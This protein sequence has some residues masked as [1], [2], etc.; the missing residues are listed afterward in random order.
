MASNVED[1]QPLTPL[2]QGMVFH[3]L[4]GEGVDV[5]TMQTVL[6]LSG[7]VAVDRLRTAADQLMRRHTTL[8]ASFRTQSSGQFVQVVYRSVDLPWREVDCADP[9]ALQRL[10]ES[11]RTASFDLGRPPLV[12]FTLARTATGPVLIISA[13]HLLWDGWSAPVLVREL[14]TLYSGDA[15]PPVRPFRDYLSWLSKQ[16]TEAASRAWA[17]ALSGLD[18]PTLVA[19]EGAPSGLPSFVDTTLP[20]STTAA[21]T[22]TA[23]D[24]GLT[25]NSV[26]QAAWALVL[27]EQ[28]GREDVVFGAT[29]SGRHPD[30]AGVES[31][32]GMLINTVPARIRLSPTETLAELATR[33]QAEQAAL[34]DHQHLGLA[35]VQQAAGRPTLFDTLLAFESYPG[36]DFEDSLVTAIESRDATHYPLAL[37]VVP[38]ESLSLRFAHD[39]ARF[40]AVDRVAARLLDVLERFAA[41]PDLPVARLEPLS[42]AE[43]H[44][45]V[46]VPNA[47][48]HPVPDT[49]LV[50][51]FSAQA[52]RTPDATAV[53]YEDSSLT[54]REFDARVDELA[55]QLAARG[56]R[57]GS[58]VG[59]HL[60]RSLELIIAL[61]AVQ[62]AG[63]AYLPLDPSYPADRLAMMIEDAQPV[64]V[65]EPG[66]LD[67]PT[68]P[69]RRPTPGDAAY[70]IFTSG[71]TGR[72]KGV[73]VSQRAIVNH[74]LWMQDE[75]RL[76]ADDR[77][78]QKTPSSFDISVW[79]FFW[80]LITGATLVVAKPE[81]HKDPAYLADLIDRSGITTIHFVPSMFRAFVESGARPSSL[82]RIILVGEALPSDL[83]AALPHV[84]N[85]YGPTEATLQITYWP[86]SAGVGNGTVPIGVPCWNSQV[87]VLDG[88]LRPVPEGVAGELYL[89]GIQLADGYLNRPGLTASRFVANP[90]TA[91][92]RLYRTGD[93]VRWNGVALEYLGR[94]DDQVKIRGIRVELGEIEAALMALP[95]VRAA[96]A[97]VFTERQQ[98]IGYVVGDGLDL[99]AARRALRDQLPEQLVPSTIIVLAEMPLTPNGKLNRKAL[100]LPEVT[101]AAGEAAR[102]PREQVLAGLFAD[103]LGVERVGRDDD[104][105]AL[106]GHSLLATKLVSRIRRTLN[107]DLR[108]RAVFDAPTVA[109]LARSLDG[110]AR[111]PELVARERPAV[112]PMSAAQRSLWFLYRLEGPDATYNVP[113]AARLTGR[114]DV[115][116]LDAA[117]ADV[118][119]RH[120]SL[121]TLLSDEGQHV[122]DAPLV[123]MVRRSGLDEGLDD[124]EFVAAATNRPFRLDQEIP[125]RA[126]LLAVGPAE[127]VLTLVVHHSAADEW[128]A[129]PLFRDLATAY[130]ARRQGEAP[131]WTPLPVQYA[132]FAL[133]QQE[134]PTDDERA[135]WTSKLAGLPEVIALPAD[136]ARPREATRDAGS[137]TIEFPDGLAGQ[138]RALGRK[139]GVTELMIGQA[140]TAVLLAAMGAGEDVPLG[141]P[142]AGRTDAAVDDVVGYFVN[143]L[144]LRTDVSGNPTFR[145]L[146]AQ[147]RDADL[148][149]FSHQDLPFE[150]VVDALNP[151][152]SPG[153][154][155]LFQVMVSRRDDGATDLAL[156]DLA[157]EQIVT[158]VTGAK[159]DLAFHFGD[160]D[161]LITYSA[162]RF[163]KSTVDS[164]ARRLVQVLTTLVT[165]P[166]Q[167]INTVDLLDD[168]ERAVLDGFNDT[169][170]ERLATTLTAMVEEQVARTPQAVAVEF[171]ERSLTYAELN[172]KANHLARRLQ[173]AGVGPERTVGMHWERSL[174]LVVGLLAVEKA[175]G[176]F[177]PLEPSWPRQRIAEV[178]DSARFTAVLSGPEHDEPVRDLNIPVLHV[179]LASENAENLGVHI[180]PESLAYVIYTSGSTGR[181]KGAMIRHR[182]ITHR[183]LWQRELLG[184]GPGDGG[185]FKAPLGF[186]ISIN[187]VFLPLTTGAKLVIA[188]PGGERDIDYLA[189]IIERHGVTYTYLP[190]SIL[191]LLVSLPDFERRGRSLKHVWCGGEVLTP[192]LFARFRALSDAVMY[193]GYGPAEATIGVSHIVYREPSAMRGAVSIGHPNGNTQLHVLDTN[194]RRVPVGVP[195]ELYA[196]GVYL[197]R[198]YINDPGRTAAAFVADPFGPPGSRLYRTGDLARWCPDGTLEFL[199]RADNQIKIRGM[200]VELEE[201]EAVLEQH[202]DVR[203]AVV[204]LRDKRLVGYHIGS[205]V[206][207]LGDWL[208]TRLPD[209]M[210]PQR[211]VFL[212]EFPLLPSGKVNRKAL[213]EPPAE[214][215]GGRDAET[216]AE[217]LLCGLMAEVLKLDRVSPDDNFF[218]LGGDSILSIQF[219]TR[220]R[221]AGLRI[222]PRQVFEF[223][224]AAALARVVG[225]PPAAYDEE[226]ARGVGDVPLTPIIRWWTTSG[227]EK[228][229]QSALLRVPPADGPEPFA[230]AVSALLEHH[231]MLRARFADGVLTVPAATPDG[232]FTHVQ[233]DGELEPLVRREFERVSAELD[234]AAGTLVRAVWFDLGPSTPGRLLLAV[235]HLAVDSVSWRVLAGDLEQA[236]TAR[237]AGNA[238]KLDPVPTSF[239]WWARNLP[240]PP[241]SEAQWW[242]QQ[243]FTVTEPVRPGPTAGW[244]TV[245]IGGDLAGAL[246]REVPGAFRAG[247]QDVLL[248]ALAT[249][250]GKAET[251]ALEGHGREEHLVPGADL[252]HTVG[253]FTTVYPVTLAPAGTP[254]ETLKQVKEKLRAVPNNGIGYGLLNGAADPA[255]GF[256]YLGRF[257]I[258]DGYWVPAAERLPRSR[259]QHR[260]LEI[261]IVTE[262]RAEGPVLKATWS[263]TGAHTQSEVDSIAQAWLAALETLVE[264]ARGGQVSALTP[265]DVPL[266]SL[267]Q[268]QLDKIAAKWRK[269]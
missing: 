29:V 215:T 132:D 228:M 171:H 114:L 104:F 142:V 157:V 113:F 92:R 164:L 44:A 81:G 190:S 4:L 38:G 177:V 96:A 195:G 49:T 265:S 137:V 35:D 50:E 108:I 205:E 260:P 62:R 256:N 169:A 209:H 238:V 134:L 111:R 105:F 230:E 58:I 69:V 91:G 150:Q 121:R 127:H 53:V 21:L 204:L 174:E 226:R 148:D 206:D 52:G 43:F 30:V 19:A 240:T 79:E 201:I 123:K 83:G 40:T 245:E 116:A 63:A 106:G 118:V 223:Q 184:F 103:V 8:R 74:L 179:D 37:L 18:G 237:V 32:V 138:I 55:G 227:D 68:A 182:A 122:Q 199:G 258:P 76:T 239:R 120:E 9:E 64:V 87:Y 187:E 154:H 125:F 146:L 186:D 10:L 70:V 153:L 90:F 212:D 131:Q 211:F 72:P 80:P 162:D 249:A 259:I 242:R 261:D 221:S 36:T 173:E 27:G 48:A 232:V 3:A 143:T 84:H 130:A 126:E 117:I 16:D 28:T 216:A 194:L 56:V 57:P 248:A 100:P 250:L 247:V 269:K 257:D 233:V 102:D 161:C 196:G 129:R 191:D 31:I 144:V 224:N 244:R 46:E 175:G 73:V 152:R 158:E 207:D 176:A 255:I 11:D 188:E 14:L 17:D 47:T 167:R 200:R 42:P 88:Y 82:K 236:F 12:R 183:L 107:V 180:E 2:Q 139:L 128:S 26:V 219:V 109:R 166:E 7:D 253:W 34:L 22:R 229:A 39:P 99:T 89:G 185:L 251:V 243:A 112:V 66:L 235:H 136:R 23:R 78:L 86:A 77:V 97:H 93:V 119:A 133:W 254:G 264:Q 170:E 234:P 51:L 210:V 24:R 214:Q 222:S 1:V 193:H 163:D 198:G 203:R 15:L 218:T 115:D 6:H 262:D 67:G 94:S 149:A 197:G 181:P 151:P 101:Q 33:V 225:E 147:V 45:V 172:A 135:Y 5:Y 268:N 192:E 41:T 13:H 54:Y 25:V 241:D 60:D 110:G 208:R 202:E 59:V 61:H 159:F 155:P 165:E 140:A 145:E 217:K 263:W 95:G 20:A 71:S 141:T 156:A 75:Y 178:A 160:D 246:L 85:L 189:E 98:L 65:L 124:A 267:P 213:P 168:A 252:S 220:A 266:V 231:D